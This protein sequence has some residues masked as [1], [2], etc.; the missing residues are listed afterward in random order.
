M[1][2]A[3]DMGRYVNTEATPYK[4]NKLVLKELIQR[5]EDRVNR[6]TIKQ[7]SGFRDIEA[8]RQNIIDVDTCLSK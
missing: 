3:D 5:A 2:I 4:N 6:E 8:E 7:Q 1:T